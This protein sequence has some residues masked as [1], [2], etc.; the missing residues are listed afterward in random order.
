MDCHRSG[1]WHRSGTTKTIQGMD[2]TAHI[3][4]TVRPINGPRGMPAL[5]GRRSHGILSKRFQSQDHTKIGGSTM[6]A[7][8]LQMKAQH[9]CPTCERPCSPEDL[10]ECLR[11]GQQ[12]CKLDSWECE[13][14]RNAKEIMGRVQPTGIIRRILCRLN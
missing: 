8:I 11:C 7:T 2:C 5:L 4:H 6:T 1:H 13:C 9:V 12:F 10:S 3:A 14:D